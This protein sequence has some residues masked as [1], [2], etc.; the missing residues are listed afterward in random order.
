M[1][2][3]AP[4]APVS[5]RVAD[6]NHRYRHHGATDVLRHALSDPMVGRIALVSAFGA[7]SVALLHMV[8]V[9]DRTTPVL[10]IDTEMLF[11]ETLA[12]QTEVTRALRLADVRILRPE[13]EQLFLR[14][15]DALLH[16]ADPD[17]CCTLRKVEPLQK[18]LDGF[19]A[20]ITGRKRFQGGTRAGLEFFEADGNRIKV[21]PLVNWSKSDVQDYIVNNRLPRHPLVARGFPSLGCRV[22]TASVD[23]GEPDRAGRWQGQEKTECG[24]HFAPAG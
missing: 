8:S 22:C 6:L 10:F 11:P 2:L 12:Y 16:L 4:L 1:P 14:D 17:A 21:N 3:E 24:I 15:P 7:E 23:P 13:R 18:G 9:L 5:E 19:D 20:W